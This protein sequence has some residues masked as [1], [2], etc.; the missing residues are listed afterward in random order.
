MKVSNTTQC[1][2]AVVRHSIFC[3]KPLHRPN[4]FTGRLLTD[5]DFIAEQN[6]HRKKQCQHNLHCHG[7]G[8]VTGLEVS[9]ETKRTV[10]PLSLNPVL[11]STQRET[12][13][14][15]APPPSSRCRNLRR[16]SKW[17]FAFQNDSQAQFQ[18]ACRVSP[19]RSHRTWK[20]DVKSF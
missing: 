1:S 16:L 20:K 17:E 8:V 11:P 10:P 18:Q 9:T 19:I 5:Q 15:S 13:F 14:T 4:Y 7:S 12:K 3:T 2:E 6:Y